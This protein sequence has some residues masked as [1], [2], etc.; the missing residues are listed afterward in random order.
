MTGVR[1]AGDKALIMGKYT[2]RCLIKDKMFTSYKVAK[3]NSMGTSMSLYLLEE[4]QLSG[5]STLS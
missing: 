3:D 4:V 1:S 5:R 2:T